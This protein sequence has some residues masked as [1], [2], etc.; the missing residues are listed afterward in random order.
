[1]SDQ[2]VR[3]RA[4]NVATAIVLAI[5]VAMLGLSLASVGLSMFQ[6][7]STDNRTFWV[8]QSTLLL[9]LMPTSFPIRRRL[10]T[11]YA[12]PRLLIVTS[13]LGSFVVM[14]SVSDGFRY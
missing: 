7:L 10:R 2:P 1:M 12:L 9:A 11:W 6:H 5:Y 3:F 14:A 4:V 13:L 8:F